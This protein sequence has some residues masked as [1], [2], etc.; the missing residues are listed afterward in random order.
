MTLTIFLDLDGTLIDIEIRHYAV[1]TACVKQFN[2]TP[3]TQDEYW[4]MKRTA[5][6]WNDILK[7]SN[8][9]NHFN[10]DFMSL[11][12]KLI[13]SKDY[14]KIDK[15]FNF[16]LE[17][18]DALYTDNNLVLV[19]FRRNRH[20]LINQLEKLGLSQ[21]FKAILSGHAKTKKSVLSKK[22]EIIKDYMS[23]DKAAVIVGDTEADV[24][25]GKF[26]G[27]TT[28]SVYSGIRNKNYLSPFSP[29]YLIED[30]RELPKIISKLP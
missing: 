26:L 29:D 22:A 27:I 9:P 25:A 30:I 8:V 6:S 17:V 7:S 11:F 18:L 24:S 5:I 23:I 15:P 4:S 20:E 10:N 2:G 21:Y 13:E 16:T 19:S 1:Y 12:I 14:L 28:V 3:L